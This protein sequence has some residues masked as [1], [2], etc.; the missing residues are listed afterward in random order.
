ML[1]SLGST[2][3]HSTIAS[4]F[5]K[6]GKDP[7]TGELTFEEAIM[8]L[9]EELGRPRSEK[10]RI[11]VDEDSTSTLAT[12]VLGAVDSR[13]NEVKLEDLDFTGP[14]R[15]ER[16]KSDQSSKEKIPAPQVQPGVGMQQPLQEVVAGNSDTSLGS[17]LGTTPS[18]SDYDD[19]LETEAPGEVPGTGAGELGG[20][21][22]A[23]KK[24]K[25]RFGKKTKKGVAS[26]KAG[27]PDSESSSSASS[28]DSVERV[29]NVKS[30]PLCHRP[31]MNSKAE[32]DIITHLAVC[33]SQDWSAVD[34]I[35]VGN[36]VTASQA[37]R[38]WYTK[39]L[40]KVSAGD[41]RLGAV[42]V[43]VSSVQGIWAHGGTPVELCQ[44]HRSE[45]YDWTVGGREDASL[46]SPWHSV[47]V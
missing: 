6:F 23:K 40:G 17:S 8:C 19:D 24:R 13:G 9:E 39:V 14:G 16:R 22:A 25:I 31:R 11:D 2:L 12:P 44:Y 27:S 35:V 46:R 32:M 18:G 43:V 34:K 33:A 20:D 36:F 7:K 3:T 42:S 38:K 15:V 45:S 10:K 1:D 30:C 29:I 28:G 47:V 37:Q 5:E 41:Y 4:F 26:S 21:A